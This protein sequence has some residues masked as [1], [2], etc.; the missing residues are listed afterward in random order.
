MQ[1]FLALNDRKREVVIPYGSK[2]NV[3]L[4]YGV[5]VPAL[6]LFRKFESPFPQGKESY[7][8]DIG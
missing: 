5:I 7:A 2:K 3:P 4:F 1:V 6:G 8:E